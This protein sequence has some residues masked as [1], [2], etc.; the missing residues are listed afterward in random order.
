MHSKRNSNIKVFQRIFANTPLQLTDPIG[1]AE[2]AL[3]KAAGW[4]AFP[5]SRRQFYNLYRQLCP[6]K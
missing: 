3:A 5:I 2:I 1:A 4:E 6:K